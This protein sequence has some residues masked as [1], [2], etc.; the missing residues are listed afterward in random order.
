LWLVKGGRRSPGQDS[1]AFEKDV[2]F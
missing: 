1:E 2:I